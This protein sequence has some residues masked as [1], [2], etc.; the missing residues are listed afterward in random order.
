MELKRKALSAM[1]TWKEQSNGST[2]LLV[3]GARRVGKS[4]VVKAFGKESYQSYLLIDFS[5][6]SREI[7]EAF[8]N[9]LDDLD[10]FFQI[11]SIEMG[12]ELFPRKSLVIFDEVQRYPRAREAI[13]H[14]V[15]D[16]R[17]DFIET[18]SL[19]SIKENV[20]DILIP[21]EEEKL[22]MHP[23]DFEEFLW[24]AGEE[25]LASYIRNC[26]EHKEQPLDA[27]HKK[28]SRLLREYL[29]V[30]GMPQSVVA[31]FDNNKS[32]WKSDTAKRGIL[33]LY[34][35]DIK[36]AAKKYSSRVSAVFENIPGFLSAHDK[37]VVLAQINQWGATFGLYDEPLFW[38][39]DS[40]MC[41]TAYGVSDP[42]IGLALTA[43]PSSVKC[44]MGDTG[45]LVSHAFSRDELTSDEIYK[46]I[47]NGR[48]AI[49]EG[50]LYENLVAQML[51][52][53]GKRL[54]F[55]TH[56]S[57]AKHRNDIEIDF[58]LSSGGKTNPKLIPIEV[59]SSTNYT[60][61]SYDAFK[62]RFG[63]RVSDSFIVH[64]KGFQAS[65]QGY[66]VPTYMFFCAFS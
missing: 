44:Y 37:K 66:K 58:L 28:A 57:K 25:Q 10:T 48:M 23:L 15:E 43:D 56:Y 11:I 59:K 49:N 45:L 3:E 21:S 54:Y 41:N 42:N 14:L 4:T 20:Q 62:Q 53:Q 60:T 38:L 36:K 5:K 31:Y 19:I 46:R 27:M 34:E 50:M 65:D 33:S 17:Y 61:T 63:K 55:Y 39:N 64:P 6:A 18:G 29:L 32:F 16:G 30:G 52:A 35:A 2:A 1:R 12:V 8:E 22:R 26:W 51:V 13:K 40:M 24:A 7:K 9:H 47:L